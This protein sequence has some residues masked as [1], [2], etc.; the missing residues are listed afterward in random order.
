MK[1]LIFLQAIRDFYIFVGRGY[2]TNAKVHQGFRDDKNV[3]E[4][5][6]TFNTSSNI[7]EKNK[8]RVVWN[9]KLKRSR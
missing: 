6:F 1:Y 4:H 9:N 5:C 2:V 3:E 7:L 8:H